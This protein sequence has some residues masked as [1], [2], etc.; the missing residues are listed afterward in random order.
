MASKKR[1][2]KNKFKKLLLFLILFICLVIG[3]YFLYTKVLIIKFSK[4]V[5]VTDVYLENENIVVSLNEEAKCSLKELDIES[6]DW[7]TSSDNKCIFEFTEKVE[8][9]YTLDKYNRL[10]KHEIKDEFSIVDAVEI[11]KDK[12]YLS[13]GSNYKLD[14]K[15]K[16]KGAVEEKVEFISSNES[17]ATVNSEGVIT[18][19]SDGE[20]K[21]TAMLRDKEKTI[22]VVVS[23]LISQMPEEP[24]VTKQLL[25]CG[26]YSESDNDLLDEIL[27]DRVYTAGYKTRAGAV[28]AAR[29]LGLEFPYRIGYFSENGRMSGSPKVD[30]EGRFYHEGLYLHKSRYSVLDENYI[31]Y[32]PVEWGCYMYSVP[33]LKPIANGL[34]CS[35]FITWI[36]RQAG[37]ESGDLGAGVSEGIADMTD[38]GPKQELYKSLEEGKVKVGDLLSGNGETTNAWDGGH[39]AFIAGI[40]DGKYYVAE[41]MWF[42]TGYFGA[43]IR[44]YNIEQFKY[45]FYWHIDMDDYYKNDGNLTDYWL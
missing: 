16:V 36:L 26:I 45:Y 11:E 5:E 35:G 1:K 28:A 21:I 13:V 44:T 23:S 17:I 18:A 38:L 2:M 8:G 20:T 3:G 34:D 40:H 39:I 12:Y 6:E 9:V 33:T 37:F 25:P 10:I 27:R 22:K 15:I 31:M 29:F 41:E 32:G 7:I 19:V 14:Y 30:G 24:S 43:I 4:S 42:G